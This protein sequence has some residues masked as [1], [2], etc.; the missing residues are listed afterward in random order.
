[1]CDKCVMQNWCASILG[2]ILVRFRR[3]ICEFDWLVNVS[4]CRILD[5]F[6][7]LCVFAN[8]SIIRH[9]CSE[10]YEY[11]NNTHN[12]YFVP[13]EYSAKPLSSEN[14]KRTQLVIIWQRSLSI[15]YRK[16]WEY[17]L[18]TSNQAPFWAVRVFH[19]FA[20]YCRISNQD[21]LRVARVVELCA[22][23]YTTFIG[24][25]V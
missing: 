24:Y 15:L 23:V 14:T 6:E 13:T 18:F 5:G 19:C 11:L 3:L 25:F 7:A 2:T 21:C 1:M 9:A 17:A 22:N 12:T 20:I 10:C 4:A 16:Y 8:A